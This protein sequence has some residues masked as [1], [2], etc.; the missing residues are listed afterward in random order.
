MDLQVRPVRARA[1]TWLEFARPF[2]LFAPALGMAS[3]GVAAIGAQPPEPWAWHLVAYPLLGAA[4]AAVLNAASNGLNQIYDLE[5][6]R[7]NKPRR[8]LP[9]GRMSVGEAWAFTIAAFAISWLLAWTIAPGGRR[10]TFWMFV[11]ASLI[12][13]LYSV[14][15]FR[16][17]R[18][19]VW[20]NV[21][22]AIPRGALLKVAGWSTV[23]TAFGWEPWFI[24]AIFGLFLL[25]A[26]T[27]KDFADM[28]G[29]AL[30]GCR[31]LPLQYGVRRAAWMISPSFV[32]PFLMINA[33]AW[34]G[35]LTGN[36]WLLQLLGASM[37]AY[38][39]YVCFLMLRRPEDLAV[40]ENHVS[41]AH[42]Y[43][44]MFV[45]QVGFALAYL[46]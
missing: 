3:G 30:G 32:V 25:G 29:D 34:A 26:T 39:L 31:T 43:R 20:A 9:S 24:G 17:K 42:M 18:L 12:T 40:E 10:H 16:T 15:P 21:T 13:A 11:A 1:T 36:F 37:A 33:G 46:L 41:W 8:P 4:A 23:K 2:T 38:G 19:G 27:T 14:P 22:V 45:A 35:V 44:M 7:V 6:D 28:K 5:I